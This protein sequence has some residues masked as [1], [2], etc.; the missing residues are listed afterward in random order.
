MTLRGVTADA[1][2]GW[3][4]V[5]LLVVGW[6]LTACLTG[7]QT[8]SGCYANSRHRR[9]VLAGTV[10]IVA[11]LAGPGRWCRYDPL[12]I[13]AGRLRSVPLGRLAA[14]AATLSRFS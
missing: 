5:A 12:Q 10:L 13:L 9:V 1:R 3:L 11:H 2:T 14:V 6:D 7:G 8:L 4:A